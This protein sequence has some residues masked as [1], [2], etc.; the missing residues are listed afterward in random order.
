[1]LSPFRGSLFSWSWVKYSYLAE[2]AELSDSKRLMY[3]FFTAA[4]SGL[5]LSA[6]PLWIGWLCVYFR[7]IRQGYSGWSEILDASGGYILIIKVLGH[8]DLLSRVE[9]CTVCFF[10]LHLLSVDICDSVS[11]FL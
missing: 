3:T 2:A 9:Q 11:C 5:K 8:I 10:S 4:V 7:L 1:M 6:W